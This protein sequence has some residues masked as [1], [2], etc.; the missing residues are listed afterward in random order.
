M[1]INT[2]NTTPLVI[3]NTIIEEVSEFEYLGSLLTVDGGTIEDVNNRIRKARIAFA[4]LNH[5]WNANNIYLP[6]KIN[7]FN[8]CVKSVLLYGCETWHVTDAVTKSLQTFVNRCLRRILRIWWPRT[9]TNNELWLKTKQK[10]IENEIKQRKYGWLGHTLRK[11]HSKI[12]HSVL[13]WNPQ[14]NRRPGRP[15]NTWRRTIVRETS[16]SISELRALANNRESWKN[17]VNRLS[18]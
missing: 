9:I 11:P 2:I 16:K 5:V 17:Y 10:C 3:Q 7:I 15:K 4:L 8:A 13:E 6:T 12:A 18:S 14:G 1:R